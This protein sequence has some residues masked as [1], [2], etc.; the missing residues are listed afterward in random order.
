MIVD[1]KSFNNTIKLV[2]D[3]KSKTSFY[4]R[5]AAL[6]CSDDSDF[7]SDLAKRE[8]KRVKVIESI[9]DMVNLNPEKF[10]YNLTF[11]DFAVS[12]LI[13]DVEEHTQKLIDK[14]MNDYE[15]LMY[16]DI[17][18]N[19]LIE[20]EFYHI[21]E[22][23]DDTMSTIIAEIVFAANS[24]YEKFSKRIEKFKQT[25]NVCIVENKKGAD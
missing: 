25:K 16:A 17:V 18:M 8:Q 22:S 24:Q 13:R 23:D 15:C 20:K 7:W 6:S 4:F 10:Y 19:T 9:R 21:V 12:K 14:K 5:L 3:L 11:S 2:I 1:L